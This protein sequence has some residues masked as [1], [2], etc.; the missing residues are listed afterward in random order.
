MAHHAVDIIYLFRNYN[1]LFAE[2][3]LDTYL[4]VSDAMGTAWLDFVHGGEPWCGAE[5]G[6]AAHFGK[7]G[8]E[9]TLR[10]SV[11]MDAAQQARLRMWSE[12]GLVKVGQ[13]AN[14]WMSEQD[15][16]NEGED[17]IY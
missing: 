17:F 13:I 15:S 2:R 5:C 10:E 6:Q 14:L 8:M 7:R 16:R 11:R 12:V 4:A 9:K 1:H 3:G